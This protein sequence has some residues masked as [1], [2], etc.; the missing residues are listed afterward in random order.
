MQEDCHTCCSSIQQE[1]TVNELEAFR[2]CQAKE[3]QKIEMESQKVLRPQVENLDRSSPNLIKILI[4]RRT[5]IMPCSSKIETC[6]G[7]KR[8]NNNIC[9]KD[10]DEFHNA[11]TKR[12]SKCLSEDVVIINRSKDAKKRIESVFVNKFS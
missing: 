7:E 5:S 6:D 9:P 10:K 1:K 4:F 3:Y 12:R 8:T 11:T 2:S